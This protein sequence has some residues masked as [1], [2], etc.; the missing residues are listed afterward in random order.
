MAP[1]KAMNGTSLLIQIGDGAT[2]T[3]LFAHDCLINTD[4]GIQFQSETNRQTIPDCDTPD[5]LAWQSLSMDAKSATITG[6]GMVH[7]ASI[8][9]WHEWFDSG[10]SKNVRVLLNAVSAANGGGHWAGKFKLTG[11]EVT[12]ARNEKATSSVTLESDGAVTW[13]DAT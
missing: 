10:E 11:W 2:P 8:P 1:V 12:G 5:A 7:T 9:E 13:V 3:E 4:R 6:A